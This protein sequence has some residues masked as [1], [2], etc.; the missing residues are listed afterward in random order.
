MSEKYGKFA[1]NLGGYII[2]KLPDAGNY[3]YIYKNDEILVKVDQYGIVAAQIN[4][5]VG[6]AVFKREEREVGLPVKALISDGERVFDNFGVLTADKLMIMFLPEKS[7]YSFTFGKTK[8]ETE[9]FVTDKGKRFIMNVTIENFGDK[10][11]E[12]KILKCCFPYLNELLM[13][14]WDKPEWY[15]RTEYLRDK[16]AFLRQGA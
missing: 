15:T 10:D 11:K 2:D 3:E 14:P 6:E 7:T 16:N 1:D 12:Y 9:V 8:V 4:P 5:P 13:A